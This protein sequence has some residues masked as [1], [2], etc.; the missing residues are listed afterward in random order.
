MLEFY[1]NHF[2]PNLPADLE[3]TSLSQTFGDNRIAE[4]MVVRFTHSIDMDWLLPGLRPT[5]RRAEFVLAAIM[6]STIRW[7]QPGLVAQR[8][9]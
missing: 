3:L 2:I 9:S 4:E 5:H 1:S 7:Q 6:S 8:C